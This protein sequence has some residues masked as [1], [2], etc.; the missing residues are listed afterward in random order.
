AGVAPGGR[1]PLDLFCDLPHALRSVDG[2]VTGYVDVAL[3]ELGRT[4]RVALVL[5]HFAAVAQAVS[6]SRRLIAALPVQ[7]ARAVAEPLGLD[8]FEPP[9]AIPAPEIHA[10][11][12]SRH[13]ANPAHRWLREQVR[14]V[15]AG[16]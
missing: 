9:L 7:F 15:T 10:F 8:V 3:A 14:H 12:H 1:F 2:S 11:W 16:L 4:R 6:Q 13:D 5:P